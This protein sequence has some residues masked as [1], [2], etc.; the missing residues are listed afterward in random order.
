V[1][2]NHPSDIRQTKDPISGP[3]P[4]EE[5]GG[6]HLTDTT[7]GYVPTSDLIVIDPTS[8]RR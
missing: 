7:H 8:D 1:Q 4:W 3:I 5:G 6:V 2:T